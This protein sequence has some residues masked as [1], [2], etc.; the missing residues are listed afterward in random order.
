[1][2]KILSESKFSDAQ[3]TRAGVSRLKLLLGITALTL[4][5][6]FVSEE[7]RIS[8]AQTSQESL[9]EGNNLGAQTYSVQNNGSFILSQ[10]SITKD[11]QLSTHTSP[12][13][14]G[15]ASIFRKESFNAGNNQGSQISSVIIDDS[16]VLR[17]NFRNN[18][19]I[20]GQKFAERDKILS[21]QTSPMAIDD[22][23]TYEAN[24]FR[25]AS[26]EADRQLRTQT[27]PVANDDPILLGQES[28]EE[29]EQEDSPPMFGDQGNNRW[30]VQAGAAV[31]IESENNGGFGLAGA[32][33]THFFLNGHSV[34]LEL[35]GL[36]FLQDN[37]DAVGANLALIMR[38]HVLRKPNWSLYVDGGAGF[39][40]TT[41]SVPSSGSQFNFTPQ[42]GAGT[43]IRVAD[44]K[45]LMLGLRWHHISNADLYD[46]NPGFDALMGY[47]GLNFPF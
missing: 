31:D 6:F 30:Y 8:L 4:T 20:L 28:V 46:R 18:S 40:G 37:E 38:W 2:S 45:H 14:M 11:K 9:V 35:N 39:I 41:N 16:I 15:E 24:T 22:A 10:Q 32:G 23:N 3:D 27:S 1:M 12:V 25:Q 44:Q 21:L 19:F 13:A 43:T 7:S 33:V 36:G 29:D 5:V 42:V 17:N 47:V 26:L 34:N